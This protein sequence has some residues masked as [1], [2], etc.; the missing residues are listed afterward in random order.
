MSKADYSTRHVRHSSFRNT[1]ERRGQQQ[2]H[3]QPI[4]NRSYE[5]NYKNNYPGFNNRQ[6]ELTAEIINLLR[7]LKD[8]LST[9]KQRQNYQPIYIPYPIPLSIPLHSYGK[10]NDVPNKPIPAL[11]SRNNFADDDKEYIRP[12][13]LKPVKEAPSTTTTPRI[14]DSESAIVFKVESE[15][16]TR[17]PSKCEAAILICCRFTQ[18]DQMVMIVKLFYLSMSILVVSSN[19]YK[20]DDT[21]MTQI[22]LKIIP[23][24]EAV[25]SNTIPQSQVKYSETQNNVRNQ[26]NQNR[27]LQYI[28]N[29]FEKAGNNLSPKPSN[30]QLFTMLR[31]LI[32]HKNE[33]SVTNKHPEVVPIKEKRPSATNAVPTTSRAISSTTKEISTTTEALITTPKAVSTTTE[34]VIT[35]PKAVSTTEQ[36]YD[37]DDDTARPIKFI[38]TKS[39]DFS[40]IVVNAFALLVFSNGAPAA[41]AAVPAVYVTSP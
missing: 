9:Q 1:F 33:H 37:D 32:F 3:W 27:L 40:K 13:M 8:N 7:D 31:I 34:A 26:E 25:E 28:L 30:P 2:R 16:D 18:P 35:T 12:I 5:H 20:R 19:P 36:Y 6:E 14:S 22:T 15:N 17:E 11:P 21:T 4:N 10:P 39:F 41:A 38:D 29:F 24:K 23:L